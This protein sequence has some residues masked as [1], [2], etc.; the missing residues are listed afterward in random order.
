MVFDDWKKFGHFRVGQTDYYSYS[1]AKAA[2]KLLNCSVQYMLNNDVYSQH[3][4]TKDPCPHL[5]LADLYR[6]RAQQLRDENDYVVLM[7]SGGPDSTNILNTFCD[8]D[9]VID[10]II[11]FN[12]Y[13]S[14]GKVDGTL[15]NADFY[16]NAKPTLDLLQREGKLQAKITIY[17]EIKFS[18]KHW[19]RMQKLGSDDMATC[20]GGPNMWLNAAWA[21]QYNDELWKRIQ[22]KGKV[23]IIY[24]HDKPNSKIVHGKR[25]IIHN[26]LGMANF[27]EAVK[28]YPELMAPLVKACHWFYA[29]ADSPNIVMKQAWILTQF[30]NAHPEAEYYSQPSKDPS[31]RPAVYWPSKHGHG[32]LRYDIFH[33]I[34]Y[35]TWKPSF[36]TPKVSD[37]LQRPQDCWWV[38]DLQPEQKSLW[39]YYAKK[40]VIENFETIK[41][42]GSIISVAPSTEPIYIE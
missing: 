2:A 11:N 4:W 36:V 20:L 38:D 21:H 40:F 3:D 8:N 29:S 15:T 31:L 9:L 13:S 39:Q 30:C 33:S 6:L 7:F 41:K 19:A 1:D 34:I 42:T 22:N 18:L 25:A 17:D 32:N 16:Y 10:E 37:Q 28:Q 24:G 14:T 26:G 12:S 5:S 35:P 23:C 27:D